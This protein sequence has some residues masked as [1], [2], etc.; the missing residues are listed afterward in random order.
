MKDEEEGEDFVAM[1]G[2]VV[3]KMTKLLRKSEG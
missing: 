2:S 1:E 3:A